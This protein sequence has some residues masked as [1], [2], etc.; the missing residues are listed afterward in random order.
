MAG[1]TK[2]T[3]NFSGGHSSQDELGQP[4]MTCSDGHVLRV[5]NTGQPYPDIEFC[6]EHNLEWNMCISYRGKTMHLC[7][8]GCSIL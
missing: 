2:C 3:S 4:V 1:G 7:P 8:E 5:A 6:H